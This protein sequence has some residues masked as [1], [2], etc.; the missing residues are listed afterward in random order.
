LYSEWPTEEDIVT[1]LKHFD[2]VAIYIQ[3]FCGLLI[4]NGRLI[5]TGEI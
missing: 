5:L 2:I 1:K 4:E 3:Y